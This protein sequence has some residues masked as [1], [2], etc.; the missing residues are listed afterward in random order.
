MPFLKIKFNLFMTQ[1]KNFLNKNLYKMS[2]N[3]DAP[4]L[5]VTY[6]DTSDE[7]TDIEG[8]ASCDDGLED[9]EKFDGDCD[10]ETTEKLEFLEERLNEVAEVDAIGASTFK[11]VFFNKKGVEF[12]KKETK[13]DFDY[14]DDDLPMIYDGGEDYFLPY[15]NELCMKKENLFP[16]Y[17]IT[18]V[19][20]KKY[21]F[22]L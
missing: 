18:N 22:E 12:K 8:D 4:V 17:I 1:K 21:S 9:E 10:E 15:I 3:D 6:Y 5:N 14:D 19:T 20:K 2:D 13:C 11:I 7:D 16:L